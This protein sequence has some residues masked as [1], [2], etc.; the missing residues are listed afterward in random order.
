[1]LKVLPEKRYMFE[2]ELT[3]PID[4]KL[5]MSKIKPNKNICIIKSENEI[6]K[7]NT[8]LRYRDMKSSILLDLE[9]KNIN[10]FKDCIYLTDGSKIAHVFPDGE[11]KIIIISN[12]KEIGV[13][14]LIRKFMEHI[15]E[16]FNIGIVD[17]S[18][19]LVVK[20]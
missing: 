11:V 15:S 3:Q 20:T 16:L 5:S 14:I 8:G 6:L 13:I 17:K 9:W 7:S 12:K 10:Y 18:L 19:K 1:M 4:V 2:F